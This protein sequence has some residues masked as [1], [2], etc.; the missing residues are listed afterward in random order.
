[1]AL[2]H[3][4]V[5]V[6]QPENKRILYSEDIYDYINLGQVKKRI[7]LEIPDDVIQEILY[8][9]DRK[10]L[11]DIEFNQWGISVYEKNNQIHWIDFLKSISGESENKE[12]CHK[13]LQFMMTAYVRDNWM[14]WMSGEQL[15]G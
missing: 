10:L 3:E 8:D 5:A 4:F 1:M 7:A 9:A 15:S 2:V 6:R 12:Y 13:L 11:P 14:F